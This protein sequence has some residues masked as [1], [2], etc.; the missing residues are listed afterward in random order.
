MIM[1]WFF[2]KTTHAALDDKITGTDPDG[3]PQYMGEWVLLRNH[4]YIA[5]EG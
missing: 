3:F 5:T 4:G 2:I 1:Q